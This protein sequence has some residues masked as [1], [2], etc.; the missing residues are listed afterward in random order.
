[1]SMTSDNNRNERNLS[2]SELDQISGGDASTV[3][4]SRM[5]SKCRRVTMHYIYSGGRTVCS[6]CGTKA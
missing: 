1:M 3:K 4:K 5:C 2:D 6:V